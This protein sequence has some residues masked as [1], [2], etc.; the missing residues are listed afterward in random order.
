M[1]GVWGG[2]DFWSAVKGVKIGEGQVCDPTYLF[3]L[4]A[5]STLLAGT[6]P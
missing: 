4:A 1:G 5:F 2:V 6:M 3:F